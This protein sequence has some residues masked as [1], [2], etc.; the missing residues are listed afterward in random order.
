MNPWDV[1]LRHPDEAKGLFSRAGQ[2][3]RG[4]SLSV[5]NVRNV[6]K[7][8]NKGNKGNKGRLLTRMALGK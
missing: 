5:R 3:R 4:R 2:A 1:D 7:K 8:G 6:R